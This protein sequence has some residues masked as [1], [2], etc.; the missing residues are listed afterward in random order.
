MTPVIYEDI[1]DICTKLKR[2]EVPHD[3]VFVEKAADEAPVDT[4]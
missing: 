3:I 1:H 4:E 2:V